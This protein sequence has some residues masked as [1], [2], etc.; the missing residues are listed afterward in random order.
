MV[1]EY[2]KSVEEVG[3]AVTSIKRGQFVIDSFF[4]IR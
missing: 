2:C 1:H 3:S 4:R